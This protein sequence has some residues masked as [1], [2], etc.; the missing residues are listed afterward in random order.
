MLKNKMYKK[1]LISFICLLI[2]SNVMAT[3]WK[4]IQDNLWVETT[5]S[6]F[7]NKFGTFRFWSKWENP[8]YGK[9][10]FIL[11]NIHTEEYCDSLPT[12][13]DKEACLAERNHEIYKMKSTKTVMSLT[14]LNCKKKQFKVLD[15]V[16]LSDRNNII[17]RKTSI[18]PKAFWSNV[19]PDT[20]SGYQYVEFCGEK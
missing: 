7:V 14:E 9:T 12:D 19:I 2:S 10:D 13:G 5:T 8:H 17:E 4:Q 1:F 15:M 6:D 11:P 16:L 20:V 3:E 18:V